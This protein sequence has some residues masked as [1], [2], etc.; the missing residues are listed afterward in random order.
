MMDAQEWLLDFVR[1]YRE[2][3]FFEEDSHLSDRS[4]ADWIG[5]RKGLDLSQESCRKDYIILGYLTRVW[6]VALDAFDS[7]DFSHAQEVGYGWKLHEDILNGWA[8]ISRGSFRP[9]GVKSTW[10]SAEEPIRVEFTLAD[11]P[12]VLQLEPDLLDGDSFYYYCDLTLMK[13]AEALNPCIRET[14]YHFVVWDLGC[15]A[16]VMCVT[17][18]EKSLI[19]EGRDANFL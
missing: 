13:L 1:F 5:K 2:L 9:E 15:A 8:G 16:L 7:F 17:P 6:G 18:N 11:V 12:H 3:G 19:A 14:G 10:Q 4:I